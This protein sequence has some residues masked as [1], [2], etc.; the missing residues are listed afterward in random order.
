MIAAPA[1]AQTVT[2]TVN[3]TGNVTKKCHV[4]TAGGPSSTFG[5]LVALG[6]LAVAD[7]TM[8]TDLATRFVTGNSAVLQGYFPVGAGARFPPHFDPA[9][10][11]SQFW[12]TITF[13]FSD[14]NSG[15]VSWQPAVDGY[16][17]GAMPI[18][19]LTMPAGLSCP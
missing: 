18:T 2:G 16:T 7:G 9:H 8:A 12:G 17:G 6:E 10:V 11:S 14:C 5:G 13:V 3:I 1:M 4:D 19:R 15:Q